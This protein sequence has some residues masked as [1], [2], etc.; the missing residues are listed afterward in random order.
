M[1]PFVSY[2]NKLKRLVNQGDM[3][4]YTEVNTLI[5]NMEPPTNI[6]EVQAIEVIWEAYEEGKEYFEIHIVPSKMNDDKA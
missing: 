2:A 1:V 5:H 4:A 6:T 3:L